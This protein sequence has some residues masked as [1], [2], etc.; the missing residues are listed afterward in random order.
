MKKLIF[1]AF[2]L[3]FGFALAQERR[4]TLDEYLSIVK[5]YHPVALQ[6]G[7]GVD[8]AFYL[9][10]EAIG[11]FDPKLELAQEQKVFNGTNYY[12]YFMPQVKL[13]LWY[14]MDLKASY[15]TYSG[16]FV[17]PEDKVPA[18]GLG[19]LG[20]SVPLG[21][22]LLID[23]RRTALKQANL[24]QTMAANEREQV[25][26]NLFVEATSS[27][28][29]WLNNWLNTEI[30]RQ[31]VDLAK[32]RAEGV[33]L[34][35][36]N[37]DRPAIDTLEALILLQSRQQKLSDYETKLITSKND[38][39]S[40]LWLENVNPIDPEQLNISPDLGVLS[41][42]L[43]DSL[44][45]VAASVIISSNPE[46]K[47][48]G[49]K[50]RQLELEKRLK[51][52][53]LKP[54]LNVNLGLL[55]SG[56]NIFNNLNFAWLQNN[57]KLGFTLSMPLTFTKQRAAFSLAK[58]KLKDAEYTFSEKKNLT[59]VKWENYKNDLQNLEEQLKLYRSIVD[60]SLSLLR[61]EE[62]KFEAG[63]SSLFLVNSREQKLLEVREMANEISAKRIQVIQ[64]LKFIANLM[65]VD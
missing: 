45:K 63:E 17:N 24:F 26:N 43:P 9:R 3:P 62:I 18:Q 57:Q 49:L 5:S 32:V 7:I 29:K 36:K 47:N 31:A 54:T 1:F 20:L 12:D 58:L 22:G 48:Y 56:R 13:P 25:L 15:T 37:G 40:F 21:S 61:G 38:L 52:E 35:F 19:F 33:K 39:A 51:L 4:L 46:I 59:A 53:Q 23:E 2:F 6:A 64:N 34:L 42:S 65:A 28:V 16:N 27:Y 14:G 41:L 60:N 11:A 55:N 30:Y 44:L 8:R 10:R 50:I